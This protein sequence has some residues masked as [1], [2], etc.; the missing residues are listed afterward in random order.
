MSWTE[1]VMIF[2]DSTHDL[3]KSLKEELILL[4]EPGSSIGEMVK[5][6]G[7]KKALVK[8]SNE[9]KYVVDIDKKIKI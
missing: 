4:Q 9:G 3:V 2:W 6:M 1:Q 8:I 7:K 5:L